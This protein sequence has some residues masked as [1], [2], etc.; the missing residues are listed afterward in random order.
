VGRAAGLGSWE[1]GRRLPRIVRAGRRPLPVDRRLGRQFCLA[2]RRLDIAAA[3][4]RPGRRRLP[5]GTAVVRLVVAV[6]PVG[7]AAIPVGLAVV[8]LV[9][10]VIPVG[11]ATVPLVI[12]V[13]P[14]VVAVAPL[15]LVALVGRGRLLA[16]VGVGAGARLF[17][18]GRRRLLGRAG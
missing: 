12:G 10:T 16:R 15:G 4:G 7:L 8:R 1:S 9:V 14:L 2:L 6:V 17:R 13:A 5:P 18:P 3:A 11:L